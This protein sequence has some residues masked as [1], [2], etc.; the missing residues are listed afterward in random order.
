MHFIPSRADVVRAISQRWLLKLWQR[1]LG[2]DRVPQWQ[3]IEA[4]NL[5]NIADQLNFLDVI[6]SSGKLRFIIRFHGAMIG[7]VYGSAD[8][9][10]KHLDEIIPNPAQAQVPYI[11]TVESG[12]P[13]YTIHDVVDPDQRTVH[14]ERLL[15][16]FGRDGKTVD[17]ILA[18]FEF[19]CSEGAFNRTALMVSQT[20]RPKLKLSV[21]IEPRAQ[22]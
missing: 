7:E 17:R 13:V 20:S 4:Q 8:C 9:R 2:N 21:T 12:C 14:F 19:V 18:S 11:R 6:R 1:H 3:A 10:G 15:L 5:S 22:A 16:P